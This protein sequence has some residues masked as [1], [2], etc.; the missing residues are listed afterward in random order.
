MSSE[1]QIKAN[2][3]NS[4]KSTGPVTG[5]GKS[6]S[7]K[8]STKHGIFSKVVLLPWESSD[9]LDELSITLKSDLDPQGIIETTLVDKL[10]TLVWRLRRTSEVESALYVWRKYGTEL[11]AAIIQMQ[12]ES[13]NK[14][15]YLEENELF[16]PDNDQKER[17]RRASQEVAEK[18]NLANAPVPQMGCT[19]NELADTFNTLQ[20]YESSLERT[21]FVTLHELQRLQAARNGKNVA[22]PLVIDINNDP[23]A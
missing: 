11:G 6:N 9:E 5:A 4:L 23:S 10:I 22:L 7:A 13:R 18:S 3:L 19:F 15:A 1:K 8:N 20:R 16:P 21:F 2:K 12:Q 14:T 17:I